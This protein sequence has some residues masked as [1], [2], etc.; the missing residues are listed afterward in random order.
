MHTNDDHSAAYATVEQLADFLARYQCVNAV[1]V[2]SCAYFISVCFFR[3]LIA[4]TKKRRRRV[5]TIVA[6]S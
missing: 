1:L 2:L 5:W 3:H 6:S 4:I